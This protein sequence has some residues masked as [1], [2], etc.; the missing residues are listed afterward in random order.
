[1]KTIILGKNSYLS[2]N[3]KKSISNSHV[4]SITDKKLSELNFTNCNII[5]NSFYSSLKLEKIDS[6]EDFL[7]R[8][9]YDLSIFLDKIK[10]VKSRKIIYSS[11]SSIYNSINDYDFKDERNRKMYSSTKYNAENLIKNFCIKNKINLC[12]ARIFNIFGGS[13]QF[14]V[15]SKIINSFK[16]Q[17]NTLKLINNGNSIRDFVHIKEVI[18][19]YK[20][21]IK[22]NENGI[23]DIGSGYG[24]KINEIINY[25]G[26][27]NFTL[28][29]I[30]KDEAQSSIGYNSIISRNENNSLENFI[31]LKLKLSK[32]PK[33]KRFFSKRRNFIQDY[34][35]GSI[36]YGAGAAGQKLLKDYKENQINHISYFVDDDQKI[37]NKKEIDGVK[38]ITFNELKLLSKSK[39][40][41]NII[42]A[43]P[44][45]SKIK[46][47]LLI[48][49]LTPITLSVSIL[50]QSFIGEKKYLNLSDVSENIMSEIFNRKA[51]NNFH[52]IKNLKNKTVLI[53][54]AGGSIGSELVKQSLICDAKVIA[55]DHSELALYNLEKNI[56]FYLKRKKIK[57]VLGSILDKRILNNIKKFEKIDIIFHAAAYK[58]VNLLEKNI[59]LAIENN[60]FGTQNI[61]EVFNKHNQQII[62][63]STDKAARPKSIV[64]ATKRISEIMSQDYKNYSPN[65]L[66]IKIVRFG[67]VF[68]SQG[69]AIELFIDQLNK[70]I[71]ITLTH[72]KAKRYFM[73]MQEACNLVLDITRLRENDQIFILD[74]G[75]QI[76]IKD[77]IY[78]LASLKNISESQIKI[79]TI[80]LKKGEKLS[81]E[82][83]INK[84]LS[85]TKNKEIFSVKERGYDSKLIN[86]FIIELKKSVYKKDDLYLKKIIF[87]F[88]S[89]EK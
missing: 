28:K 78:K 85:K 84:T 5:I 22:N 88:L 46:Q 19:I 26:E 10:G 69:S 50:N 36:I 56:K 87:S 63:I 86:N 3:L 32:K 30:K 81:E 41:N 1:M 82:L 77:I 58:H 67:N 2:N 64:G 54:G 14:S 34:L 68:G 71:P 39:T 51:K 23:V 11:S 79:H 38:V 45:L 25:L 60:I 17:K 73:S 29:N 21:I 55:L 8:S 37:L 27:K 4:Y 33:F 83:S 80:G 43:I 59:S 65:K 18:N 74:M 9:L 52:L 24:T 75:K 53:T 57:I 16:N 15:I 31:K 12:I 66:K 44:S 62:I 89:K 13:E 76:L 49:K 7:K 48:S 72:N 6:Y 70:N 47:N 40:I 35:Q 20:K 42:I 61:L